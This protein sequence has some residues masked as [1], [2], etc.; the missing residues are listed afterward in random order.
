MNSKNLWK[1]FSKTGKVEDYL[2]YREE[3]RKEDHD[4]GF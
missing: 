4:K 1:V 3:K 2:K